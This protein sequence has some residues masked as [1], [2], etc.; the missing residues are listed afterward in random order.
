[1]KYCRRSACLQN[2]IPSAANPLF[3]CGIEQR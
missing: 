2:I 3:D 1:V